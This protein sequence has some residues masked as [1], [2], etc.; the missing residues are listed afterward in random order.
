MVH[1]YGEFTEYQI[2]QVKKSLRASIFY[3]LLYVD[4][5]TRDEYPDVNVAQS[6]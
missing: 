6:I 2:A 3:L 1:L 5:D 4:R